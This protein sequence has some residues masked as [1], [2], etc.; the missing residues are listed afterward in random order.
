MYQLQKVESEPPPR[1]TLPPPPIPQP[2][3]LVACSP[4]HPAP[5]S[6]P[7]AVRATAETSREVVTMARLA[8]VSSRIFG[9]Q[10]HEEVLERNMI[11][12]NH[13]NLRLLQ[14][15]SGDRSKPASPAVDPSASPPSSRS[16]RP[17]SSASPYLTDVP[18]GIHASDLTRFAPSF[19]CDHSRLQFMPI[20]NQ[21]LQ[22]YSIFIFPFRSLYCFILLILC[23][24]HG[25][26]WLC[27]EHYELVDMY[28][29]GQ[30]YDRHGRSTSYSSPYGAYFFLH[31]I[32]PPPLPLTGALSF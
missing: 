17:S 18:V 20:A 21:G 5:S 2:S 25:G 1:I 24:F 6:A 4:T 12:W 13:A 11:E 15:D 29:K 32:T 31:S 23:R 8:G 30:M 27:R 10:Q 19:S 22:M 7:D 14:D 3:F 9:S 28:Q 26:M 16:P